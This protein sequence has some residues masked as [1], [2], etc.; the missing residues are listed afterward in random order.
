LKVT[1]PTTERGDDL[2]INS[3]EDFCLYVF[4]TVDD[5][6]KAIRHLFKR[7]GPAPTTCSDSELLT[8]ALVGEC[9]GWDME[10]ELLSHWGEHRDLFPRLPS[11]SRFNRRR[12]A[13]TE[14]F[15]LLRQ[16]I[17]ATFDL[18]FGHLALL[19]SV[20][21]AVVGFH[22]ATRASAQ[23]RMHQASYGRVGAKRSTFFGYKLH[24]LLTA[25]GIIL[26]WMLAP[27]HVTDLRA[28]EEL[29]LGHHDL[30]VLGDKAYIS[31]DVAEELLTQRRIRLLTLPKRNH[32]RQ[33]PPRLRRRFSRVRRLIETIN[34]Q[35][36]QQFHLE[37]N[38]AHTFSGLGSRLAT[39]LTAH[40]LSVYL[41]RY[42]DLPDYLHIKSLPFPTGFI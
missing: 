3:F 24:L 16:R 28:G 25:A 1:K 12:R 26:D 37:I 21:I 7:P 34:S 14:A 22:K 36:T 10:T 31:T 8:L 11:Q 39:K 23:W 15:N 35:L 19:D 5:H 17:L 30:T 4:V 41:N 33:L 42:L 20:P 6:W 13:L 18:A 29:L 27:A 32:R 38:H 40:V 9:R 2:M